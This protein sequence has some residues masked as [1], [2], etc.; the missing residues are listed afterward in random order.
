MPLRMEKWLLSQG[1]GKSGKLISLNNALTLPPIIPYRLHPFSVA[2]RPDLE[3]GEIHYPLKDLIACSGFPEPLLLS[4]ERKARRWS[5]L[6]FEQLVREDIR[7][8]KNIRNIELIKLLIE[9]LPARVVSPLSL[10]SLRED[11]QVAY[12][13]LQEWISVSFVMG[14]HGC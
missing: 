3:P 5:R 12:A 9:L 4:S 14:N 13:T 1:P 6:R 2:E 7:D 10:N 11:L 8:F